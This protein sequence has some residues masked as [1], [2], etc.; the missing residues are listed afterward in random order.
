MEEKIIFRMGFMDNFIEKKL[1]LYE[2]TSAKIEYINPKHKKKM[3]IRFPAVGT[4][5]IEEAFAE[6][7]Q[8]YIKQWLDDYFKKRSDEN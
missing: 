3:I 6:L 8:A 1:T 2:D 7:K 4:I 5:T